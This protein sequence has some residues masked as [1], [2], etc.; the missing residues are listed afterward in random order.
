[1]LLVFIDCLFTILPI[2][3]V[4]ITKAATCITLSIIATLSL[5]KKVDLKAQGYLYKLPITLN[6]LVKAFSSCHPNMS[7]DGIVSDAEG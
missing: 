7:N 5:L 6:I 4:S 1:M 2:Y 3:Q